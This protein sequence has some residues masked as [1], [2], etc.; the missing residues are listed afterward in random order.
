M[1]KLLLIGAS[2]MLTISTFG[3]CDIVYASTSGVPSATGEINDP[4]DLET[5]VST[6]NAGDLIRIGVGVYDIDNAITIPYDNIIMEGGFDDFNAW[7]KT[8]LAGATTIN[9]TT[10]NPEGSANDYRLVAIYANTITGFEIHDITISTADGTADGTSTYGIHIDNCSNYALIRCVVNPGNASTGQAGVDGTGG[11]TGSDG[12]N[13]AAGSIDGNGSGGAGG[14]G[15]AGAGTGAGP[16]TAGGTNPSG[17]GN[18]GGAGPNGMYSSNPRAG[19]AGGG[20]GSGGETDHNGGSGGQGGGINF[21][22]NQT[23]GGNA[24]TWGDPGGDGSNGTTGATGANG[25]NGSGGSAGTLGTFYTVGNQANDGTDGD[26]GKGGVG[27][28]GGGGQSC[29][30]CD[31]GSGDGGGGGAGGGEGGTAGTGGFGGGGSFAV[32]LV[33]NGANGSILN[34]TVTPG[35]MGSGGT[36]GSGGV[37]GYGSSYGSNEV[38]EGGDGGNGGSGGIGGAGGTG[39]DGMIAQVELISGDVLDT[40]DINYDLAAQPEITMNYVNCTNETVT[41]RD[42]SLPIG[43]GNT[44]WNFGANAT[45]Q[46][47]A[48]NPFSTSYTTTGMN[49]VVQS[50]NTYTDFVHITCS[51][52][53]SATQSGELLTATTSGAQYQ[54]VDC[55]D[56]YN[57]VNGETNQSYTAGADGDYAVIV[58]MGGCSDTSACFNVDHSGIDELTHGVMSIYPNPVTDVM[59][60]NFEYA[61]T[62]IVKIYDVSGKLVDSFDIEGTNTVQH[63]LNVP[64]GVYTL[65]LT[66]ETLRTVERIVKQ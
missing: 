15:G 29:T 55:N 51:V 35:S 25:I 26:G 12:G 40:M 10:A 50:G 8:S 42:E 57:F 62:G 32:Y 33:N 41:F 64:K 24:G 16:I 34:C 19:G 53:A 23:G 39:S 14:T 18:T 22:A 2:I 66:T 20:G 65:E 63:V 46:F 4:M 61:E 13:G 58:T 48:D 3:Q 30:F 56:G 28:G 6:A 5:A 7:E 17:N 31:D 9:R 43:T 11:L 44:L 37:R 1:R 52:D 27:G 38:G 60:I 47:G 49:N 54:W 59:T 21:G 36:G 45:T